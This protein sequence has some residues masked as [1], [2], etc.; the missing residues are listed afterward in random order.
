MIIRKQIMIL[1]LSSEGDRSTDMVVQWL[2]YYDRPYV[3]INPLD[4][5]ENSIEVYPSAEVFCINGEKFRFDDI[6]A[7]WYRRFGGYTYSG[8]YKHVE[9]V[10]GKDTAEQLRYELLN[11]MDYFVSLLPDSAE[12]IGSTIKGNT[13]KLIELRMAE[14][15]GLNV[16]YTVVTSKRSV[17]ENLL[18]QKR[19]LISKSLYNVSVISLDE[20]NY[21][22]FTSRID[23]EI[24]KSMPEEFFPSMIQEEIK[25]EFEVRVFYLLDRFYSMAIFSQSNPQTELDFRRYDTHKPNRFVPFNLDDETKNKISEFMKLMHLNTGSLDF[26]SA[27]GSKL[28]FLE[29]NHMGQF[30]MVDSPCNYGIHRDIAEILIH[31]DKR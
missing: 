4:F 13:N 3:R 2:E 12:I 18:E 23:R 25:K 7:V 1:L 26:I 17:I 22:M 10:Y 19:S 28:Y 20:C 21:T 31:Y 27:W 14:R 15:A 29:V 24:L 30:G 8:H 6:R 11:I 16:P 5:I 9:E